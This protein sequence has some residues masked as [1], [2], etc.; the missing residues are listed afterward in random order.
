MMRSRMASARVGLADQ[1][2]PAVDRDLAGDQRG[3][4]AVAVLDD[5]QHVVALLGAERLETPI[6]EDQ[7]LDAAEGAHQ[8]GIAAIA[9]RQREIAEHPRDALVEHRAVVAA[10]LVAERAGEPAFA[11]AGGPFDDQVL[12]LVDP[13]AGDQCLEQGAVE[14]AGGAII[15]V[16]DGGLMAQPGKAQPAAQPTFVAFGGFAVEQQSEPFGMRQRGAG[17]VRLELGE[18]ARHAGQAEL[19]ELFEGGMGQHVQSPNQLW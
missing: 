10:R 11:D 4:A 15:D 18:G 16:L 17:R 8:A 3:A 1:V 9:A 5:L 7:Q 2:V 6:V 19:V 12:R 14:T 13:A